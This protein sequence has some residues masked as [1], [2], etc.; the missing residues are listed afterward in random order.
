MTIYGSA[1]NVKYLKSAL[2]V[3]R[4]PI[5][6][7]LHLIE[8]VLLSSTPMHYSDPLH[9][10]HPFINAGIIELNSQL[11]AFSF[12][13]IFSQFTKEMEFYNTSIQSFHLQDWNEFHLSR[14][15]FLPFS[16]FK[17][18]FTEKKYRNKK[19]QKQNEPFF[20]FIYDFYSWILSE[21]YNY[22]RLESDF[23]QKCN[24]KSEAFAEYCICRIYQN[25][26]FRSDYN[27]NT[28]GAM[29][30]DIPQNWINFVSD[31]IPNN[32]WKYLTSASNDQWLLLFRQQFEKKFDKDMNII[33]NIPHFFKKSEYTK[34]VNKEYNSPVMKMEQQPYLY[35]NLEINY[36]A[37]RDFNGNIAFM[38]VW[39]NFSKMESLNTRQRAQATCEGMIWY[40]KSSPIATNVKGY[41]AI[42]V[43]YP[44]RENDGIFGGLE[45]SGDTSS[46][47]CLANGCAGGGWWWYAIG[48]SH[49][50][51]G[52]IPG[53]FIL[54]K[55]ITVEHVELY[56]FDIH[57][58]IKNYSQMLVNVHS[59]ITGYNWLL[60][61]IATYIAQYAFD[62][63]CIIKQSLSKL[64]P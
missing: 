16:K 52:K 17:Q 56:V 7:Q 45:T 41:Q 10:V 20:Q 27:M 26:D 61:Y 57:T 44:G 58:A 2:G 35:S 48:S 22:K 55:G 63:V 11:H 62:E 12:F 54:N 30:I 1:S 18:I 37:F 3:K 51:D 5:K 38:I 60:P 42:L 6:T 47:N 13:S 28:D 15:I 34:N 4:V 9:F 33:S 39:P 46:G 31:W 36:N 49:Q 21:R 8:R 19:H 40:Q 53:P 23:T 25:S 64:Y 14:A 29:N 50:H 43:P 24:S 32:C 59:V